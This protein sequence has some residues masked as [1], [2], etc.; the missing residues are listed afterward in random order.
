MTAISIEPKFMLH[1]YELAE[2]YYEMGKFVEARLWA[3]KVLEIIP[4][5]EDDNKAKKDAEALLKK[6]K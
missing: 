6:L 3:Q 5:C 2:T 4:L 1:Q